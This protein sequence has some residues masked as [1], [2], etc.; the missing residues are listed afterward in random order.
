[1]GIGKY[2]YNTLI[3]DI[4]EHKSKLDNSEGQ[5]NLENSIVLV[6]H[7]IDIDKNDDIAKMEEKK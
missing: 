2:C 1:M 4:D 6:R 3:A 7:L 5:Y